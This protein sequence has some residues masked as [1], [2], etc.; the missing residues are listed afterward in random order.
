LKITLEE[1]ITATQGEVIFNKCNFGKIG[2]STDSRTIKE[3][4]IFIPIVGEN[5]DGHDFINNALKQGAVGYFID[6]T[7]TDKVNRYYNP[8][9]VVIA[10]ED[11]LEAYLKIA[12]FVKKKISPKVVAVTGSSGKTT[13]KEMIYSVLS[14]KYNTHKSILNHNNEI[15]LC[16]TLMKMPENAEY[17]V[18]EMGMRGLGEISLLSK[19]AEPDFAVITNVGTAH[20]G[21]LGSKKNIARA[22]CEITE[23]MNK[24]GVLIAHDDELIKSACKFKGKKIFYGN[25]FQITEMTEDSTKFSYENENYEL[26]V[27]G[28]YNVIN[29]IAAIE[30][31]KLAGLSTKQIAQGLLKY[32]PVGERGKVISLDSGAKIIS[33]CYNA[34]PDSMKASINAVIS[35]YQDAEIFLVLGDMGELG[36]E[37]TDLHK[38][39]GKFL[40]K[41]E[42]SQLVTVGEKARFIAKSAKNNA[43]INSFETNIQAAEYLESQ[44][45]QNSV[46]LIKG[47]RSMK[48][49]EISE[50]LQKV[51]TKV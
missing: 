29:A 49:E 17:L 25:N 10:V 26:S 32:Q 39:I 13:A 4:E 14:Q 36:A 22:K 8:T 43:S 31:G 24:N 45:S 41:K 38:E 7:H 15:G 3:D 2:V 28:E 18:A 37:E 30:I 27:N 1:I 20:I 23:H 6:K 48:M 46:V 35:T 50:S 51:K 42:F 40:S 5:F 9:K 44:L 21:R 47:S 11:T 34:N 12:N 33:D 16:Q 19:Y